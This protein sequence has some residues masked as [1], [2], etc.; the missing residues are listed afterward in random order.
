M[1]QFYSERLREDNKERAELVTSLTKEKSVFEKRL[2]QSTTELT[3]V[4]IEMFL[5]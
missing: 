2:N 1:L 3:E 5:F 4:H